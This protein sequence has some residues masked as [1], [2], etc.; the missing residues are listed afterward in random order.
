MNTFENPNTIKPT[1]FSGFKVQ[2]SQLTLS[3][4]A[5]S[6][7][8]RE[9]GNARCSNCIGG[10]FCPQIMPITQI[11]S[12]IVGLKTRRFTRLMNALAKRGTNHAPRLPCTSLTITS[13]GCIKVYVVPPAMAADIT[14]SV[15]SLRDL[16]TA[17]TDL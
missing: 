6:V 16:L 15:W 10:K 1:S 8:V 5:K 12:Q 14:K 13:V 9:L 2:G 3:I 4:P 17:A 11:S 7:V